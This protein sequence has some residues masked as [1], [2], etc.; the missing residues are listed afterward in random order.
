MS[1]KKEKSPPPPPPPPPQK[2]GRTLPAFDH[3]P[4]GLKKTQNKRK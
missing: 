2:S 1:N 3:K 4:K